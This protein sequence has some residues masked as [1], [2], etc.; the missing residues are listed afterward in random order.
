M[1]PT[2]RRPR[3]WGFA[4]AAGMVATL[5]AHGQDTPARQ[6]VPT[7]QV[8]VDKTGALIVPL[9]GSVQFV[10]TENK[11]ITDIFITKEDVVQVRPDNSNPKALIMSGRTA[12]LTQLTLTF[13]DR[14]KGVYDVTVQPDFEYLRFLIRQT[15]P[16]SNVQVVSGGGPVVILSGYVTRPEDA[17]IIQRLAT[18]AAGGAAGNGITAIQVGGVQQVQID[19]VVATVDRNEVRE[20][21]FD[22]AVNGTTVNF[23]S[24]VSGLV[25]STGVGIP[26]VSPNANLQL[27]IV[28]AGFFGALRAFRSEGVAKFLAEPKVVTQ[29]G[30]PAFFRAGGQQATLGPASGINGP[31]VPLVPFG[32]ELEVVP[33]VY[34]NGKIWLEIAPRVSNV[35]Q[36]L[37][38]VTAFGPT[39]GFTEQTVRS[40]VMLENGQTFAIGGLIQTSVQATNSK[41]PVLGDLPYVGTAFSSLRH[42]E[43]ESE[44]LILVT[45]RLV[46]AMDC[47]QVPKRLPGRETR[48]PDD[49]ELRLENVL[50]AARGQR[51]V[52]NGY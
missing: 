2:T 12:G 25:Q 44:I 15:V 38:I 9:G 50:E 27:G 3:L 1:H 5:A 26:Q 52:W 11:L 34:G 18:A 33:I 28:P 41:V 10:P 21:G 40:A 46:D 6:P 23:A 7:G 37:G 35:S 31:G 29:S 20:R 17:D 14:T 32:T 24:L 16:S 22:F 51:K 4:L 13:D 19:V 49:Y 30:R 47:N 39:P 48:S 36:G 8:K 42:E 45:P 43:R